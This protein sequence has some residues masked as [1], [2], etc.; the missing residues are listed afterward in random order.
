[1]LSDICLLTKPKIL[2]VRFAGAPEKIIFLK[3]AMNIIDLRLV[4]GLFNVRDVA[5]TEKSRSAVLI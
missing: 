5:V 3:D 4:A 2:C 1:M